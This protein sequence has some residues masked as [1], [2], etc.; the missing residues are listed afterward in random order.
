MISD[1]VTDRQTLERGYFEPKQIEVLFDEHRR[2]RR[3][4][5]MQLWTLFMLELWHRRYADVSA[6]QHH[7]PAVEL[8]SNVA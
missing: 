1:V 5:S 8:A 6:A 2:G 4:H 7:H 3:D